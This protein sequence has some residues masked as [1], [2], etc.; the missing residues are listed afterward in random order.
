MVDQARRRGVRAAAPGA[1]RL[2]GGHRAPLEIAATDRAAAREAVRL[3]YKI[4][5]SKPMQQHLSPAIGLTPGIIAK[6]TLLDEWI[7]SQY[8]STYHF[9]S[10][11]RMAAREKGGVV[12]QSGRVYGVAGLR[13][14][15]ASVIP[16]IPAAN[17]MWTTM[18]FAERIGRSV[19]DGQSIGEEVFE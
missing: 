15:D 16:T 8:C 7:L 5:Q 17:T 10:S 3:A 9:T 1:R 4:F 18:M 12:D 19:R 11:C 14:V 13:V 2:A 6:D